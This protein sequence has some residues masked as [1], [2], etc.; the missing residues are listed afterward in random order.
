MKLI[1]DLKTF[2]SSRI[3]TVIC[4]IS[5]AMQAVFFIAGSAGLRPGFPL[6]DAWIHQTYARN[7]M[8]L[9][10][11]SFIPG[12][13]SGGSTSPLWTMLLSPGFIFGGSFFYWW[14]I[15]LSAVILCTLVAFVSKSLSSLLPNLNNRLLILLGLIVTLEW[16]LQWAA[17]SGMETI[18][19]SLLI[20]L[21]FN[22]SSRTTPGWGWIGVICGLAIWI[23][24]DGITL[25][26]PVVFL[27]LQSAFL[28]KFQWRHL[29]N[30]L[31][32]F[33]LL[34]GVYLVFNLVITGQVF[35]NT[36]YAKQME[37]AELLSIP[38]WQ[39]I[40][41]EFS[42]L[43]AGVCVLLIPGFLYQA[44]I[45][46]RKKKI[47]QL[48]FFLWVVGYVI[49][50]AIRL[51]VIYQHG[52]YILPVIPLFLLFGMAGTYGLLKRVKDESRKRIASL[53]VYGSLIAVSAAFFISGI[54]A[55]R[56]DL[57]IIDTLM[58]QP[59]RWIEEN[60][61]PDTKI[62]VHDIGAMGFYTDRQMIDLAGLV[63]PEVIPF[64]RDEDKIRDYMQENGAEYFIG[65]SDWYV[66][67][68]E[69]GTVV[70]SFNMIV[71]DNLKEVVIIKLLKSP[72]K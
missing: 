71:D 69:W 17:V 21:V 55:Y 16:H 30:F 24:P 49:L 11:W 61:A 47:A 64:I 10:S 23:R 22:L 28:R 50:F 14:T 70:R 67:S 59:A 56:S 3:I 38:L 33:V 41:N 4:A 53:A 19:F 1:D 37:Y 51:P 25:I 52:R 63:S 32:P 46:I 15:L 8:H 43:W 29:V 12:I 72:Y 2:F 26:G 42:P 48:G 13:I 7:L 57:Q 35:P 34:L 27:F 9:G 36:F 18:L 44:Y 65:F 5:L 20:V 58:I 54:T 66:N 45:S 39:R 62:A 40:L 6:D 31:I 68:D 60:T